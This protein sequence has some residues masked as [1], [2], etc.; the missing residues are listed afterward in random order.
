MTYLGQQGSRDQAMDTTY[1]SS[2]AASTLSNLW[3][4][5]IAF[6]AAMRPP[7]VETGL[8]FP[9][10]FGCGELAAFMDP[11]R[12]SEERHHFLEIASR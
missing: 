6:G 3:L 5:F 7:F 2:D 8:A 9:R 12:T 1:A 4:Y 11:V 10:Y